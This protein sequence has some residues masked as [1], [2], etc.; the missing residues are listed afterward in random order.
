MNKSIKRNN[1]TLAM[2][3]FLLGIFMGALDSGIISPARGVI[4]SS[5]NI[6]ESASI[7]MVTIYTLTYAV[8]MPITGKL[9]DRLGRKKIYIICIIIFTIGSL[10][11]WVSDVLNNYNFLL[12][13]RLIQALGGGGIMPIATA[14]IGASFPLEKRG[15]ALGFVGSIYGI[16]TVIGPTL[17]T[18]ILSLA[19]NNNWGYLFLLN[20]P[21]SLIILLLAFR[22]EENKNKSKPKKMD[23][24]GAGVLS[25]LIATLMYAL[26]N[27]QFHNFLT[28]IKSAHVWPF[29][30]SALVA[31]PL[32]I[33]I[34]K[35]AKDPILD[36]KFFTNS[37][38][39]ITLTLSFLA[40][41][42]LMGTVFLPQFGE[43]VLRLKS[44]T[45][46]YIVTVFA[47]FTGISAPIGGKFI[48]KYSVKILLLFGFSFTILGSL[49]QSFVTS[50]YPSLSNL[51]I[52]II[53]M[54]V[55]M[56]FTMGTPIN[57]L[58]MS[59]VKPNEISI[60]Q[61]TASLFRSI[62]VAISP[63]LLVNFVSQAG[64]E[65]PRA[66]NEVLPKITSIGNPITFGK[67]L[68][69][70]I[71]SKFQKADVTTIYSTVRDLSNSMLIE[72][73]NAYVNN[74]NVNFIQMKTQYMNALE[75]SK[76]VIES[77][78][79]L[80]LNKGYANL[81]IGTAIIALIGFILSLFIKDRKKLN[82]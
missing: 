32:F 18:A 20:V 76:S 79:Q 6:S 65:L 8:S 9:A 34:E 74:P 68:P 42:G 78:Y 62:G 16:A 11:C 31:L 67:T 58:M 28:S 50:N 59:L 52:G 49:Y 38:I 72:L 70:E 35:N 2:T 54:G 25:V 33:A 55:G 48:D 45:G 24:L 15:T 4:A 47:L 46:G 60:G 19:G 14:Y 13:S 1:T 12:V 51:V 73:Q 69:T 27:L 3:V 17:G 57:Y 10:L 71:I 44:G 63:N 29:L 37:Q 39:V 77:T 43:N 82:K 61:S 81:F 56:G 22:L 21:V 7:W 66:I 80:T 30:V 41:C 53:L 75:Q 26:T 64:E 23:I 40:G 5:L 36:L